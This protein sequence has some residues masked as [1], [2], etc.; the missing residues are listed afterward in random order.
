MA[1]DTALQPALQFHYY[2]SYG[3]SI[4]SQLQLPLPTVRSRSLFELEIRRQIKQ[5]PAS[6]RQKIKLQHNPLSAFDVGCVSDGSNY[7]SLREVGECLVSRDGRRIDC[8]RFPQANLESFNVYLL[9]QALSFAL[10]KNGI[11]PLHATVVVVEGKAVGFLGDCGFGKSTLA[12]EF[13]R[14]GHRLLT[15]D[16]LVLHKTGRQVLAYPGPPRIKLL[17]EMNS[18]FLGDA[19]KSFPMNPQTQKLIVPLSRDRACRVAS[20][21]A[22]FYVLPS[23]DEVP[24][25]SNIHIRALSRKEAFLRLVGSAFNVSILD[26]R[27]WRRQFEATEGLANSIVVKELSYPRELESLP[28]VREAILSDLVANPCE[29]STCVA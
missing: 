2:C 9:G 26:Q 23:P 10:V 11:E 14:A 16:L 25:G 12:A 19:K 13:L 29:A 3:V 5:H 24:L 28:Q 21:F 1:D 18:R 8:Y 20:P 17:P 4:R 7:V 15:D 27:R 6:V 22:A